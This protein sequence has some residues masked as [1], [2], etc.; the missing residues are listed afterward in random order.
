MASFFELRK[1]GKLQGGFNQAIGH[2]T[3]VGLVP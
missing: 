2:F 3:V 1:G